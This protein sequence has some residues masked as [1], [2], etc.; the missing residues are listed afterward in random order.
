MSC[1]GNH[2]VPRK[3]DVWLSEGI[4]EA[5]V[6]CELVPDESEA[7]PPV[8]PASLYI[9]PGAYDSGSTRNNALRTDSSSNGYRSRGFISKSSKVG[10]DSRRA[11]RASR[12]P[13]QRGSPAENTGGFDLATCRYNCTGGITMALQYYRAIVLP[14]YRRTKSSGSTA[15]GPARGAVAPMRIRA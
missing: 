7:V 14:C 13:A 6:G 5:R 15:G 3:N 2:R 11:Q 4:L 12:A 8:V 9:P 1:F 10:G